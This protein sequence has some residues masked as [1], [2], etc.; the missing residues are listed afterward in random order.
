MVIELLEL[1]LLLALSVGVYFGTLE[2]LSYFG[3]EDE[4]W[5]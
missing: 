3:E 1:F 5:P 2:I 4:Q